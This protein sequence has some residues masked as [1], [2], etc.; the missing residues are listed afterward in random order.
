MREDGCSEEKGACDITS[1]VTLPGAA[2][3]DEGRLYLPLSVLSALFEGALAEEERLTDLHFGLDDLL[4]D[5]TLRVRAPK[6]YH[7]ARAPKAARA[8]LPGVE[9]RVECTATTEGATVRRALFRRLG[10]YPRAAYPDYRRAF[11]DFQA[12]RR[13]VLVFEKD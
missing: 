9:M 6:G 5:E 11:Q 10:E 3:P 1:V 12:V 2:V 13:E 4:T 8:S 7:L